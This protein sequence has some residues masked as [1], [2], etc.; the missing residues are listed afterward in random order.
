MNVPKLRFKE[1]QEDWKKKTVE[2]ISSTVT[3]GSR[4]WAQYYSETGDK[5]IRMTNLVREGINLDLSD[6]RFVSLPVDSSSEGKRTSLI[7]GDIL[8]SITA[9]LGKLGWVPNNF[10]TAYINQHTALIRPSSKVHSKFIAYTLSTKKYNNDLN[11]LNDSGAKAG[12]NLSTLKS[13]SISLPENLTEQTKIATFLSAVDEKIAQLSRKHELLQQYKQGMMQQLFS[14]KLRFKDDKGE[15]FPEWE[16]LN[17]SEIF[18]NYSNK[19]HDRN[20]T[21]LAA[22]QDKGIIP[23][24]Q[25]EIDIKTSDASIKSYKKIEIGNFVISLRS[26]QGGIEYSNYSG[27]CSPAYTVLKSIKPINDEFYK[28]YL[29]THDFIQKLNATVIG[30]RDGRQ[31]SYQAF[32]DLILDYPPSLKEQAKI[33]NFLTAIDNKIE[34]VAKQLEQARVWKQGLLQQMFV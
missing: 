9:E 31:I 27:I 33:A 34:A 10:G 2:S 26:F 5:F 24:E 32:S 13:F 3:S 25:I 4:D 18:E 23:R 7:F 16:K 15:D 21:I 6:L 1:F 11:S 29:K 20:L 28:N 12:L 19:N 30:I 8:V 17:A 14:Q 22:T